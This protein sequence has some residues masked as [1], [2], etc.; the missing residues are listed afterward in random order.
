MIDDVRSRISDRIDDVSRTRTQS[1]VE[2]M[3][4]IPIASIRS[5]RVASLA[6]FVMPDSWPALE[7]E[8]NNLDKWVG[9]V[10]EHADKLK[11]AVSAMDARALPAFEVEDWQWPQL[12]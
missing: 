6:G 11:A 8:Y 7:E 9:R 5:A 10:R 3:N 12:S 4:N 2:R 1:A